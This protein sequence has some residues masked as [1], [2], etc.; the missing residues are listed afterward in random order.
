MRVVT[1]GR[2]LVQVQE[3]LVDVLLQL[4]ST[5]QSLHT[6][7]PLISLRFLKTQKHVLISTLQW[8]GGSARLQEGDKNSTQ[9]KVQIW[10]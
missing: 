5:L 2:E 10:T 9:M 3:G 1:L 4:E 6:T 8:V 7:A